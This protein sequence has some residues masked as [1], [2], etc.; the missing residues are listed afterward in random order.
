M[1]GAVD[2][3]CHSAALKVP[4][5]S[6]PDSAIAAGSV[7]AMLTLKDELVAF[8]TA[9]LSAEQM[10]AAERGIAVKTEKVFVLPGAYPARQKA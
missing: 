3:L 1:D 8:R 4:D 2:A 9:Q 5:I 10:L 7:V 6:K